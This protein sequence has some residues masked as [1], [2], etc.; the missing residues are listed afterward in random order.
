MSLGLWITLGV[1]LFVVGNLMAMKPKI[2]EVRLDKLR[3]FARTQRLNPK[4]IPTPAWLNTSSKMIACYTKIDTNWRLPALTFIIDN[5]TWH[6]V[7]NPTHYPVPTISTQDCPFV[8]GISIKSNHI[9]LFW[10]DECYCHQFANHDQHAE[11]A[12]YQHIKKLEAQLDDI[13]RQYQL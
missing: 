1:I 10:H 2:H 13:A 6:S 7:N 4:L 8:C 3:T 9:S 12:F 5:N 11:A